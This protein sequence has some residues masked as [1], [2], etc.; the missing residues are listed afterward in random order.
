LT[1]VFFFSQTWSI[2]IISLSIGS[3]RDILY[4]LLPY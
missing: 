2:F 3:I 4:E 1:G